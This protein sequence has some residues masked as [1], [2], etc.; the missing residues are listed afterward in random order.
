MIAVFQKVDDL[1]EPLRK[2]S[3][4]ALSPL[5]D[6]GIRI[7]LASLFWKSGILRFK[8][9]QNGTFDNQVFL[10]ELEHPVPGLDPLTAAYLTTGAE[11]IFPIM[12]VLGLFSRFCRCGITCHDGCHRV[13]L[14]SCDGSYTLG[15]YGWHDFLKRRGRIIVGCFDFKVYSQ[16]I[17]L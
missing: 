10:F 15:Y 16:I 5:F 2:L 17:N 9:W 1:I 6:L 11:L 13:H 7:Y 8:D 3:N 14:C 4:F 12:L